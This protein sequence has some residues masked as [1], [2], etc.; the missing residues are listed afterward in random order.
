M[1]RVAA[2][3][4]VPAG[5]QHV[6]EHHILGSMDL[7]GLKIGEGGD[8]DI[9]EGAGGGARDGCRSMRRGVGQH[10]YAANEHAL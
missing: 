10:M 7:C 9:G 2:R 3:E 8:R 5:L 6:E 4:P 1:Q